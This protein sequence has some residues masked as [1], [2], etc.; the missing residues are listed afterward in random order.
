MARAQAQ[1]KGRPLSVVDTLLAAAAVQHSPTLVPD[2]MSDFSVDG[3]AVVNPW[4]VPKP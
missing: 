1:T 2:N 3:E 4:E